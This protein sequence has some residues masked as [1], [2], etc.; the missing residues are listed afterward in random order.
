MLCYDSYECYGCNERNV[1]F[2]YCGF[3]HV[4]SVISVLHVMHVSRVITPS[5]TLNR[6]CAVSTLECVIH[7]LRDT[8]RRGFSEYYVGNIFLSYSKIV[9]QNYNCT[10]PW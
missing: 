10:G 4:K 7:T 9:S 6:L 2:A 5:P 8:G 3:I 1:S